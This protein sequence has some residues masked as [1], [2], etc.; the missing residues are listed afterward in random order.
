MH[1]LTIKG[2]I[3]IDYLPRAGEAMAELIPAVMAGE[4]KYKNHV[5]EGLE[6]A[7]DAVKLLFSGAHDGKLMVQVSPEP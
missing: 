4:I 1:R 7:A 6:N 5:V 2:F 3:I